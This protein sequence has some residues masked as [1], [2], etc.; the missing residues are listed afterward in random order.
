MLFLWQPY[1]SWKMAFL[2]KEVYNK[3]THFEHRFKTHFWSNFSPGSCSWTPGIPSFSLFLSRNTLQEAAPEPH[4]YQRSTY[5][6]PGTLSRKLFLN[7][8]YRC[9]AYS[10]PVWPSDLCFPITPRTLKFMLLH[11]PP[12]VII[13]KTYFYPAAQIYAF[14]LFRKLLNLWFFMLRRPLLFIKTYFLFGPQN[15]CFHI[16][17]RT[18]KFMF[19]HASPAVIYKNIFLCGRQSLCFHIISQTVKFMILYALPAVII[20]ENIFLIRL[21]KFMLSY[22]NANFEIYASSCSAGRYYL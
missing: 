15:L 2:H 17:P 13:I 10:F 6:F 18:L 11:A 20:N 14:I 8:E 16:T 22:Y 19:L 9:S 5:S 12:A 1:L 4:W 21:S 7:S 3:S